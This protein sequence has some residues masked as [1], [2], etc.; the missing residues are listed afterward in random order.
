[1]TDFN[2]RDLRNAFGSFLTGVTVIT[3]R[4]P[5]GQPVGFT[6]NS[7]ASVSLDPPL[8]LVCPGKSLSSFETFRAAS[9]FAV[10]VLAEGQEDV[11]NT[12]AGFKG[13]RFAR[14]AHDID[15]HDVPVIRGAVARFSCATQQAIPAG[16]HCILLG[17]VV[18][19]DHDGSAGLGYGGG[20]YFSLGL[21]RA[22][23][24]SAERGAVVGAIIETEAGIL[25]EQTADGLRPPQITMQG[26]T[27]QLEALAAGLAQRGISAD[28]NR[29]YSAFDDHRLG[30]HHTYVLAT[31]TARTADTGLR[32]VA[33][34]DLPVQRYTTPAITTMMARFALETRGR[35]FTLYLG[36]E[37]AGETHNA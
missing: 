29:V 25:L 19:F 17:R 12:F 34:D 28:L 8:L 35:A 31:A 2:P 22:T 20:R 11:S 9:H 21:E 33:P 13:D 37:V 14:V 32:C 1:M 30:T 4:T 23:G 10:S 18:A 27:N 3:A 36:D 6:A 15:L 16:D 5:E 24:E 7:F 26:R